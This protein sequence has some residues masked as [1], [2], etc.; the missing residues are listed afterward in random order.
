MA[1]LKDI[2]ELAQVSPA[3][4]SRILNNDRTLSVTKETRDRVLAIAKEVG[5]QKKSKQKKQTRPVKSSITIGLFQ[6]YSMFQELEDPYYQTIRNGIEAC[7]VEHNMRVIRI[8]KTDH[9]YEKQLAKVDGLIC[10]GKY[11]EED[12]EDFKKMTKHLIIVDMCSSRISYPCIVLDFKQAVHDVM[13]YLT[14]LGHTK[15]A[16]LGGIERIGNDIYFEQR[17][18]EFINYC[19]A[20]NLDYEPYM[21]EDEFSAESGF[22]MMN[23]LIESDNIPT[24]IFAASDP[25]AIGAMRALHQAN[26]SIP[27]DISIIGFDD[28]SV[29]SYTNPPLT[30]VHAPAK[31]MGKKAAQYL[32][33][34]ISMNL[35]DE[36]PVRITLPCELKIRESCG[37]AKK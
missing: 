17:K 9:D 36:L 27:D 20:H 16:Y 28:I 11:S 25:I 24:A 34:S 7:C 13:N 19:H 26:L 6:W 8:F 12:I 33:Q 21:L 22:Q 23:K 37:N 10:V 18:S 35:E 2:S 29:A 15:I 5:Y 14:S 4:I 32:Y 31:I 3:T 30:T 1:T